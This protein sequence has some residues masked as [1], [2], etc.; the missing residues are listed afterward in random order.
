MTSETVAAGQ[1]DAAGDKDLP[2]RE[3]TR[4][5]GRVLG[6]VLREHAGSE[7]FERIEAIRRTAIRFRRAEAEG[8]D[9][10][11][12][13]A[14]RAELVALLNPLPIAAVLDVVRAFS[15]FSHLANLAEDVHQNRRRRI[16]AIAG[17]PARAGDLA[18][19]LAALNDAGIGDDAIRRWFDAA[20][21]SPVLTAHPTEVQRR[22]IL[23][24]EREIARLLASRDRADATP[25]ERAEAAAQLDALVL[26]LWQTAMLRLTRL[27]VR[28]EIDNGL[29]YYRYTFLAE[30]PRLYMSLE[31]LLGA[32]EGAGWRA[33]A[34]LRMGSWIG[35]DRDGNPHVDADT[36]AYAM[37]E[38]AAVAMTHYLAEIH[39]L[40]SELSLS[41]RLVHPSEAL[42][43]LAA[44]AHDTNPHRSDE[45]YR[46]ALIGIYARLAATARE[47]AGVDAQPPP[48]VAAAAYA[49]PQELRA[50][51]DVIAASLTGHGA[52]VLAAQRLDPLGRA[53]DV[54]GFHL[55]TVD[56]RQNSEV[57]ETVVAE[58]L[59]KAGEVSDYAA[60]D[61]ASRVALLARELETPRL[62]HTPWA[63]YTERT[64]GELAILA[65]AAG[66]RA[67]YGP[68]AIAQYV[69]SKCQSVSDMLEAAVL[70]KEVGLVQP[71]APPVKVVPLFETI[72]DLARSA[73]VM[74][75]AFAVPAYRALVASAGGLQEVM[76]GYSDSNK[77]GGYVTSN[78]ALYRAERALVGTFASERVRL[79]LFHGRGGTVGRG[80]GPSHDAILAQ[81][82]GSVAGGLR[83]T[84]QGEIIASKYS[85]PA[86][87]RRNLE[88]LV[89]AALEAGLHD[90]ERLDDRAGAYHD[91][92]EQ[93]SAGAYAAYRDLVYGT[94][95]FV[96]Y[97]RAST[98][99]AEIALLNLGSRPAS[100]TA[101]NRIEDL[102][103][104]PW[105]FSWG[106]C[107][108]MLPGW[109]GFGAAVDAWQRAHSGRIELLAEMHR[110]W[111]FFRSMLSNM[112]M[113]LAK[114][115]LAIASRYADLVADSPL[116]ER[117]FPRIVAEHARTLHHYLA[118]VGQATLLE[119]NPTL[120]RS[121]RNRFPYLDPLNHLQVELLRRYRAGAT[122][123][124]TQRAIHLT[125]NGLAAGLR[126]SG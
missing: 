11:A 95:G 71:D 68:D 96:D 65:A 80:G 69:I 42:L 86:L 40:G 93:L 12:A 109:Y 61:E 58:L 53:I 107:R 22:S 81:A 15:Y 8:G 101:S 43:A 87:G 55:A 113:V 6:D 21:V 44:G 2:L 62:L 118:I 38:Q 103:A 110:R 17:S 27:R 23:D 97:F 112:G 125:I 39:R 46:Q 45:P 25:D 64:A 20:L 66:F 47:L 117:I 77:D 36:L 63:R 30:V 9:A 98:P 79:R 94:P 1:P 14:S 4:L 84:E 37:R 29:A 115:D 5:L 120:A 119:D 32:G 73:D 108:L 35:G 67:R 105:V 72:D 88:S 124:R 106:Q 56:L 82:P 24:A 90:T 111:P 70:L 126:N 99:I 28:D 59:A 41:T 33:P 100:R 92:M 104:I 52:T 60:L 10:Q 7:A 122:D 51:L 54:F 75:S 89:A 114:T 50:D 31:R 57:H 34:F 78:W 85:D 121:I 76:L 13:A 19:A 83:L 74:R 48:Q 26:G 3:D 49:T 102:R 123:V 116:R 91:V 18:S 16:H